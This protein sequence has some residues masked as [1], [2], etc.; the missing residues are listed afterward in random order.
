MKTIRLL[1]V[2]LFISCT[3]VV[4][5]GCTTPR[6]QQAAVH[7]TFRSTYDTARTFY[8]GYL[9]L[10]VRGKVP[11]QKE[12][13]ADRAWNDFRRGFSLAFKAA[14]ADWNSATPEKTK[15]LADEFIKLVRSL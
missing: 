4:F 10:V 13:Q 15:Q 11:R 9:E 2:V 8:E 6:T 12:M 7:D 5:T 3:P 14:S 1:L